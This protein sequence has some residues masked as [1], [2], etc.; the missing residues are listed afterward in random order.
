MVLTASVP[1]RRITVKRL[2]LWTAVIFPIVFVLLTVGFWIESRVPDW[3]YW[4]AGLIFVLV[5]EVAY[6]GLIIAAVVGLAILGG[7][8][9][10]AIQHNQRPP[11]L[12]RALVL[13]VSLVL[14]SIGA[15]VVC[16]IWQNR[17]HSHGAMPTGGFGREIGLA[18]GSRFRTPIAEVA[19]R[20]SFPDPPGD[21]EIDI[22]ILGE[23]SAEGVPYTNWVSPG[24]LLTWKIS[25]ALPGRTI[26]ARV[27][28]RSGDTL[29]WQHRDLAN[30]PR[31]PDLL[32][33][34]CGHNEFTS[35]LAESR[36]LAYYF[37][38]SLP[39]GWDMLKDRV[40]SLS[41]VYGLI[42][43][44]AD[45]CRIAIPPATSGRRKLV[46]VPFYSSIEYHALLADFDRRLESIVSYADRIGALA[47]LI[48]PAANDA[49]FEPSR[50][51]LPAAT[52]R[53]ERA[54][55]AD[56]FMAARRLETDTPDTA[57]LGYRALLARY[58]GF[59]ETHF[60]LA[61]LLEHEEAWEE[62]YQHYVMARDRDGYPMRCLSD[63]Q[64]VYHRVAS[65][66]DCI[67]I[68]T[69]S[70][71]HAIGRHGL[72]DDALF[73]D[74]MHPSLR[75][76]IALAQAV[77]R[78]LRARRAFGWP[79]EGPSPAID[80]VECVSHFGLDSAAWR[81]MCL[82]G[83]KFNGLAAP[84]TYDPARRLQARLAYA[85]AADHL[86]LGAEPRSL[87][88]PNIGTPAPVPSVP[89]AESPGDVLRLNDR[90]SGI[91]GSRR[92]LP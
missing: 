25:Q 5:V 30:L 21:R 62:A 26:H 67:L 15:E 44:T 63:F 11:V 34:Y 57:I 2:A 48:M 76:Q 19:L 41:S 36:E 59:A 92:T 84:L 79:L 23:S 35:R 12:G 47:V 56:E 50:S 77:L 54:S 86:A 4:E 60:R 45:K 61:R 55:F 31:R 82:W 75:G 51:F 81:I 1:S 16:A 65:R 69:Q 17:Q 39:T 22:V 71:F 3:Y 18:P 80:P 91:E 73:Q 64:Q 33:I 74:A 49:G 53:A 32:I 90:R 43:E 38:D 72:L 89:L 52:T 13:C 6:T 42:R 83:I 85:E 58:P 70:Y 37:D 7:F 29:E 8:F 14:A 66:H 9:A 78:A 68:D 10:R 46:D 20:T 28:A 27:I 88:L 24:S 40:E 87:G